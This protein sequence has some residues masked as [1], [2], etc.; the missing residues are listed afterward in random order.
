MTHTLSVN[1]MRG[2]V[3]FDDVS[4]FLQ[5]AAS[6]DWFEYRSRLLKAAAEAD[7]LVSLVLDPKERQFLQEWLADDRPKPLWKDVCSILL[8]SRF[9]DRVLGSLPSGDS[10][11]LLLR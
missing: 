7:P 6:G 11:L 1:R 8:G 3:G 10:R 5:R 2:S 9:L 4:P